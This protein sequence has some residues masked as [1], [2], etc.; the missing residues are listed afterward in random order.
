M[1]KKCHQ[2]SGCYCIDADV[3]PSVHRIATE[4]I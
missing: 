1:D 3:V 2:Y 4:V